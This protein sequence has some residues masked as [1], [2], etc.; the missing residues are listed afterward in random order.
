MSLPQNCSQAPDRPVRILVVCAH[1]T[2][3][4]TLLRVMRG[5][6]SWQVEGCVSSSE[7]SDWLQKEHFDLLL[8]GSGLSEIDENDL[9]QRLKRMSPGT[10]LIW[11]YGGGSGLLL[12][13]IQ[14]ALDARLFHQEM[15][16]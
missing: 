15:R 1:P 16:S 14:A 3:L 2:V 13:E 8:V 9:E 12:S 11:H 10:S 4:E 7:A 5:K 6:F